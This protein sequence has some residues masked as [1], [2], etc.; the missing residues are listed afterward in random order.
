M[1]KLLI[2]LVLQSNLIF[3]SNEEVVVNFQKE[4]NERCGENFQTF[5]KKLLVQILKAK[6]K[7]TDPCYNELVQY[8]CS[9]CPDL[10]CVELKGIYNKI[11][12][13]SKGN[14]YDK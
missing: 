10:D 9:K 6:R 2:L 8:I 12:N 4:M 5:S 11:N 1:K 14:V 3:A 13:N 7:S